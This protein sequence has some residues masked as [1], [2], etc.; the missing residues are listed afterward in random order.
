[1]A[2]RGIAAIAMTAIGM[3]AAPGRAQGQAASSASS[4]APCHREQAMNQAQTPMG[5]A[6][7]LPATNPTLKANPK[8]TAHRGPYTYS[9][10]TQGEK[11]TYSVTDGKQTISFP[12]R[13]NFGVGVQAWIFERDGRFLE[14]LVSYYPDSH[15]LELTVGDEHLKPQS[16]EEAV[17][18]DLS[19]D[20]L[21]Q[22]FGC[23][24]TNAVSNGRLALDSLQPGVTCEH[25]HA[26]SNIHLLDAIGGSFA[27]APARLGNMSAED[28]SNFCGQC[29]RTWETVV[30]NHW[31]GEA[32]VRFAPYRLA[33]SKCFDGADARISCLACHDPHKNLITQA[34]AYDAKCLACHAAGTSPSASSSLPPGGDASRAKTCPVAKAEC[35]TCHMPKV[36]LPDENVTFTDHQI[37]VVRAGEG[38]PN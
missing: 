1:M 4:C 33:N 17:G 13:W 38:Y 20:D 3:V 7:M 10:E 6:L 2:L 23:H 15:G 29:H 37:R 27:S 25:C 35:V 12:I 9:I 11:S 30:R 18:R 36:K 26:G 31:H 21:K 16:L 28:V 8:L 24:A 14:S 32:N 34:S 19:Q 5:R 22:C